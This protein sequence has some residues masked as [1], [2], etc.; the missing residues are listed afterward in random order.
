MKNPLQQ[1][2]RLAAVIAL[3]STLATAAETGFDTQLRLRF[4]YALQNATEDQLTRRTLGFG[5]ELGYTTTAGR[6]GVEL[7]Y[8]Y[9][10]GDQFKFDN[11]NGSVAAPGAVV[12]L[13]PAESGD[14]RRN[15]LQGLTV[16]ASYEYPLTEDWSLRGGVQFGGGKFRHEYLGQVAGTR[17][18]VAFKDGYQ[19]TPTVNP[20]NGHLFSPFVGVAWKLSKESTVEF[21][22]IGLD[23]RSAR[24]VHVAG[25]ATGNGDR[26]AQGYLV[27][28]DRR[29]A[30]L[31]VGYAFRF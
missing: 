10:P 2:G 15:S 7:G 21:Q 19:A 29:L 25:T 26:T 20:G 6:F 4:G 9:K 22:V 17:N 31:E 13:N 12:V 27:T 23:Y 24:Y 14:V 18:G 5:L 16:R 3:G 1:L 8:Q 30:H 11:I 28:K